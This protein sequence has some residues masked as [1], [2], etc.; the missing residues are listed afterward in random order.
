M[1]KEIW[2]DGWVGQLLLATLF[3]VTMLIPVSLYVA[4]KEQ[5][6]WDAF[7][8]KHACKKVSSL[9]KGATVEISQIKYIGNQVTTAIIKT[10]VVNKT[11]WLCDDGVIYWR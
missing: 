5:R 4:G 2:K 1:L 3:F 8:M 6:E 7:S 9:T 11:G 10:P